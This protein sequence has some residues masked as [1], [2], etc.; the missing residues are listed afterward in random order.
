MSEEIIQDGLWYLLA[1]FYGFEDTVL[2]KVAICKTLKDAGI[3]DTRTRNGSMSQPHIVV[4]STT[5]PA[6]I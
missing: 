5:A 6:G 4:P 1:R 2:N 3:S